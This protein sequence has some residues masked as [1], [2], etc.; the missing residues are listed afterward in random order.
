[1]VQ[2]FLEFFLSRTMLSS[3]S[4]HP[5]NLIGKHNYLELYYIW[6]SCTKI[7]ECNSYIS[8]HF[9]LPEPGACPV[10]PAVQASYVKMSVGAHLLVLEA[11]WIPVWNLTGTQVCLSGSSKL[12]G[13][14]PVQNKTCS[15]M[16]I[17]VKS[18]YQRNGSNHSTINLFLVFETH[19]M[20]IKTFAILF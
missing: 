5:F 3:F 6:L 14:L 9:I 4:D 11:D 1:M 13:L 2:K 17:M 10:V 16:K 20:K 8:R 15:N 12:S 18:S 7:L 19:Y